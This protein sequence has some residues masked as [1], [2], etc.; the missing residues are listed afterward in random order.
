MSTLTQENCPQHFVS[1]LVIV[2]QLRNK[3]AIFRSNNESY[4]AS[5]DLL[6]AAEKIIIYQNESLTVLNQ[7][8]EVFYTEGSDPFFKD[9]LCCFKEFVKVLTHNAKLIQ[10]NTVSDTVIVPIHHSNTQEKTIQF[11]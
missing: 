9:W 11:L 5:N 7:R 2:D 1:P 4:S 6:L 8:I 3:Q 10:T